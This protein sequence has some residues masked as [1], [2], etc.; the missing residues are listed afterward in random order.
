[1]PL[2]CAAVCYNMADISYMQKEDLEDSDK[3]MKAEGGGGGGGVGGGGGGRE[4]WNGS[5]DEAEKNGGQIEHI[6]QLAKLRHHANSDTSFSRQMVGRILVESFR[7][8]ANTETK[9]PIEEYMKCVHKISDDSETAI[10][11]D[12]VD[13]LPY[14]A[15]IVREAPHLFGDVLHNGILSIIKKY[16]LDV[17]SQV[18]QSAQEALLV[19][20][21]HGMLETKII[22]TEICPIVEELSRMTV[23]YLNSG[24]SLMSKMALLIG[25]ELT[26]KVFLD[27]YIALCE[28]NIFHVRRMCVVHF[29]EMCTAVRKKALLQK[30]FP[31]F[32]QLCLDRVWGVRKACVDVMM[33]VSCC[34]SFPYR[35]ILLAD[36]LAT[37]LN[38][39]SK[40]VRTS[41]FQI[42][43]PFISTFAK[44]F[45]D[46]TYNQD[47]ELVFTSQQDENFNADKNNSGTERDLTS[48]IRY[49]YEGMFPT[50]C[51]IRNQTFDSEDY[52]IRDVL[53]IN[54]LME[55]YEQTQKS[56]MFNY[57]I[58]AH[59]MKTQKNQMTENKKSEEADETDKFN[60][61]LYYYIPPEIPLDD[62][63]VLAAQKSSEKTKA[64]NNTN[65]NNNT[66]VGNKTDCNTDAT[67][68]STIA[69]KKVDSTD[70]CNSSSSSNNSNVG[71]RT[72]KKEESEEKDDE[73]DNNRSPMWT[74]DST[75]TI[76]LSN[77]S[78][79]R[80]NCNASMLRRKYTSK[81]NQNILPQDIVPQDLVDYF[82]SMAEPELCEEG[83]IPYHCAFSFPAVAFTLGKANWPYLKK[84]YQSLAGAKQ[85]KVRRTLASSIHEIAIILGEE[86]TASDLVPIYDGFIKDLDEVR[87][88]VLKHLATFL[89]I[90]K[91]T[92][93]WHYLPRLHN[94]LVT[95]NEWN[96]RFRKEFATQLLEV[97]TLF[98]ANDVAKHIAPL[99]LKLLVDKVAA[100]RQIAL[101][102]VTRIVCHLSTDEPLAVALIQE[103]R[104]TL[105]MNADKWV[106][107]QTYALLCAQLIVGRAIS[108]EKFVKEMLPGLV[109]LSW[110]KVP[111]VRLAVARTLSQNVITMGNW[112]GCDHAENVER[113]LKQMRSDIDRDVRFLAEIEEHHLVPDVQMEQARN[114]VF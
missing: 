21:K 114:I 69:T 101:T 18:R 16:L 83:E 32:V 112:L 52:D 1:M 28:D 56:S 82:V 55:V 73:N 47:G 54:C 61:F 19:L 13:Q 50:K 84:A 93:R 75:E 45:T 48:S 105:A 110:D 60:T 11:L 106:L 59:K 35:R 49:S 46:V 65:N 89:K 25:K 87:I 74:D 80:S 24:I 4:V 8:A 58:K 43:G 51:A 34:V 107:R 72:N 88:G 76:D 113:R 17:D 2:E 85:W 62:P 79:D 31:I 12:L 96:W 68:S 70:K 40:W 109:N 94:F 26:E 44:Q 22:E 67:N 27:R 64:A 95:D 3:A 15:M 23:E 30:L 77:L 9:L 7:S 97:V 37:H 90:L 41:A 6:Y 20:I 86:I 102:L 63:L 42:L 14:A 99:S 66:N 36:I 108:G 111:N 5:G 81:K 29:G 33:P 103:L 10:R 57:P 100:V 53:D 78:L 104:E 98:N 91:P 39:D 38:D 92:Y 71:N